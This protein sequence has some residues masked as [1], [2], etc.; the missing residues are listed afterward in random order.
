[1]LDGTQL[2]VFEEH[3]S[4]ALDH[5]RCVSH[6]VC[7]HARRTR[8]HQLSCPRLLAS[9]G[10]SNTRPSRCAELRQPK[11]C[12]TSVAKAK[13]SFEEAPLSATAA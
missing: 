2:G 11:R 9:P 8:R 12:G 13:E 4:M 7:S 5:L 10:H 6:L 1:M 3:A